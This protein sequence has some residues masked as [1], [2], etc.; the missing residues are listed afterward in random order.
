MGVSFEIGC[1]NTKKIG[2]SKKNTTSA[3]TP[4][5]WI[6][7]NCGLL[8]ARAQ[9]AD[10]PLQASLG[11]RRKRRTERK[12]QTPTKKGKTPPPR[13]A[14]RGAR[15]CAGLAARRRREREN[16]ARTPAA[17]GGRG[18]EQRHN[19]ERKESDKQHDKIIKKNLMSDKR[20]RQNIYLIIK[21]SRYTPK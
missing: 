21:S 10:T 4:R 5:W 8:T 2:H 16:P 17:E 1:K 18:H 6:I 11:G 20:T 7:K 14:G 15:P 12:G 3:A 13:G 9:M 19:P